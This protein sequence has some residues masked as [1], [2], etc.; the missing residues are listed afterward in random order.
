MVRKIKG[1]RYPRG[2]WASLENCRTAWMQCSSIA[3]FCEKHTAA[4]KSVRLNGWIQELRNA[5]PDA[6]KP[7]G[8]W[9]SISNCREAWVKY[10]SISEFAKGNRPAY[11]AVLENGWLIEMRADFPDAQKARGHWSLD[12]CREV[13]RKCSSISDFEK[14]YPSAYSAVL[15]R[16]WTNEM[17]KDFP[18]AR[19]RNYWTLEKCRSACESCVSMADFRKKFPSA[20]GIMWEKGWLDEV[21]GLFPE[22]VKPPGHWDNLENCR[23]AW[24]RCSTITQFVKSYGSA[25]NAVRRNG[26]RME[27][28][29]DFPNARKHRGYWTL[30]RCREAWRKCSSIEEFRRRFGTANTSVYS[31]GW[32]EELHKDLQPTI[33]PTDNNIVYLWKTGMTFHGRPVYKTGITSLRCGHQRIQD[34]ADAHRTTSTI[35]R[36][37]ECNDAMAIEKEILSIVN[38]IDGLPYKDGITEMFTVESVE[39]LN[40]LID[41]FDRLV[42]EQMKT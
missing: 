5:F 2:H 35:L 36:Y 29:N 22:T 28:Q 20:Y 12:R 41:I 26:W 34:V 4:Y 42:F 14:K 8:Y 40:D 39:E 6:K 21:K 3:E 15:S 10:S 16:K 23:D 1:T 24:L 38:L 25:F 13:W 9:D 18:L 32:I 7:E 27:L 11:R 33:S 19:K 17:R 37:V 30:D 31:N